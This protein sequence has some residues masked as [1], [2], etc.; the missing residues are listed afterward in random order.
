MT[1]VYVPRRGTTLGEKI[2]L[3]RAF[4]QAIIDKERQKEEAK[5]AK[6]RAYNAMLEELNITTSSAAGD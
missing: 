1:D 2:D 6:N 3:I 4:R 5:E